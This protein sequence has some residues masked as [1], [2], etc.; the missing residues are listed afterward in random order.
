[1]LPGVNKPPEFLSVKQ[2]HYPTFCM[3]VFIK[4]RSVLAWLAAR[5]LRSPRM[6]IVFGQTIHLWNVER[7]QFLQDADWVC[8]ELTHVQQY[9]RYG[10]FSFVWRYL[11]ESVKKGYTRNRYE[12]EARQAEPNHTLL[13]G[14]EF[15]SR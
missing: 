14:I 9:R 6:A 3:R 10:S 2:T 5:C 15:V 1:M 7:G 12:A 4:E 13:E 11:W 8:H